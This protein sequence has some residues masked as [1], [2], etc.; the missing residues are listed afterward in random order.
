MKRELKWLAE[1]SDDNSMAFENEE[2]K[3]LQRARPAEF[4]AIKG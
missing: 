3:K 4:K 1:L 2:W